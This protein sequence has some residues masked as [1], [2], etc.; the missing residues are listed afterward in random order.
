MGLSGALP[1]EEVG[2]FQSREES[3]VTPG[4]KELPLGLEEDL[5]ILPFVPTREQVE[6]GRQLF[7]EPGL[8]RDRT[9]SCATCHKPAL[10]FTSGEVSS[11]GVNGERGTRNVPTVLNRLFGPSHFWDGRASDLASQ[12]LGPL[13]SPNEMG[14]TQD[15]F[16][17]LLKKFPII[18]SC[19]KRHSN[20]H[21]LCR[22]QP[23]PSRRTR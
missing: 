14:L 19:S 11:R 4:S 6:L 5:A 10:A 13:L 23:A 9:M 15:V 22:L 8:S 18:A 21:R 7:F 16:K 17:H 1:T 12:A 3:S 2:S 20:L